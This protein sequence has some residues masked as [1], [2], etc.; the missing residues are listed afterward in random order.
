[1]KSVNNVRGGYYQEVCSIWYVCD[2]V[3]RQTSGWLSKYLRHSR[4]RTVPAATAVTA[5]QSSIAL[6][7]AATPSDDDLDKAFGDVGDP[8]ERLNQSLHITSL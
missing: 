8:T 6:T 4:V 2:R 5:E 7:Q 1:M 3:N